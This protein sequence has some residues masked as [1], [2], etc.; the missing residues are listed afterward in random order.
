MAQRL[1]STVWDEG[2]QTITFQWYKGKGEKP[3]PMLDAKGVPVVLDLS[4][5]PEELQVTLALH[6]A[7]QK[8]S[9]GFSG[10]EKDSGG[11]ADKKREIIVG[12]LTDAIAGLYSGI[13]SSRA[14]SGVERVP[15]L[16]YEAIARV[17]GGNA[18]AEKAKDWYSALP[19]EKQKEVRGD[20]RVVAA[21]S[22]IKAERD[23]A[24]AAT[25]PAVDVLAGL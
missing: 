17:K 3:V 10:A 15:A 20:P 16:I 2:A 9:D 7:Q 5:V 25:A 14:E 6:G 18:T 22:A 23:A 24:K 12:T 8:V 19:A 1:V 4:R 21:Q 13:W 11:N